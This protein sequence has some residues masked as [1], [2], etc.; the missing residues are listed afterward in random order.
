M[1]RFRGTYRAALVL[2]GAL[3]ICTL[4]AVARAQPAVAETDFVYV[5]QAHDTLIGLGR[6]LLLQPQR[7]REV[8][9][10][11]RIANPRRIPVGTAIHIPYA[12]LRTTAE[13]AS[14]ASVAGG[15]LLDGRPLTRGQSVSQGA[16]IQTG[17]D[18]SVTLDLAD[19]SVITLQNSSA[20]R[21]QAMQ[22]ITNVVGGHDM[23]LQLQ[24]GRLQT[25]V[26]PHRDVGRFEIHTPVAVSAVRG[27]QFRT[28]FDAGSADATT[29]TL[30][31]TVG[32]TSAAG[33]V[34]VPA[35]FG[36]R[37]ERN[38]PPLAPVRLLP[39]P[40]LTGL[41]ATNSEPQL[42]LQ[43]RPV[44]GAA[45]YRVQLAPDADFHTLLADAESTASQLTM[46][47]PPEGNFWLRV[48]SIDPLGLEG[49]DATRAMRQHLLP[50]PPTPA[51]PRAGVRVVGTRTTFSWSS[52]AGVRRYR[53][54]LARGG[55][56]TPPLMQRDIEGTD[57]VEIDGIVPGDYQWRIASINA[58]AEI[59]DWSAPQRYTQRPAPPAVQP[60]ALTRHAIALRWDGPSAGVYHLQ[61]ARD[62]GFE[63]LLVD[64]QVEGPE[65]SIRRLR[66]GTYYVRVRFAGPGA[67]G[68]PFGPP[69]QF[70]V[71]APLWLR[72]ALP[73]A[74]ILIT[75]IR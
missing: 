42:Q 68:D 30:D 26:K 34:A 50:A 12:W 49:P 25:V 15:V 38:G 66:P 59:G 70:E 2:S 20:L 48:R 37:V 23:R 75:L 21:L 10:R 65:L 17:A 8:Q 60:P 29:E 71:P 14:V 74:A 72:I 56:F 32:V 53:W 46:P 62:A 31:G 73:I 52:L 36:T 54:Q 57:H 5:A 43:W 64:R 13:A 61:I 55:V 67:D 18:G 33:A 9:M 69:R 4:S 58:Q 39:P 63:R 27:T 35:D 28:A 6:R 24:S 19:G 1:R 44:A 47:A 3:V 22:K 51:A 16:L 45:R 41:P 40:D 11:N 7:W